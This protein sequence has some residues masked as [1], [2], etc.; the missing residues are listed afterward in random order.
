MYFNL[1][2]IV[3]VGYGDIVPLLPFPRMVA[4]IEGVLGHFYIAVFVAWL[5]GTFISQSLQQGEKQ[6]PEEPKEPMKD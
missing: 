2:T 3:G 4:A 1:I 6:A 5:V